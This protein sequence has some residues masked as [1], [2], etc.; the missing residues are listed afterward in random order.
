MPIRSSSLADRSRMLVLAT[1]NITGKLENRHADEAKGSG[2]TDGSC[3][4][5]PNEERTFDRG[6]SCDRPGHT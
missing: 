4:G 3:Y 2:S 1:G 6:G 5:L